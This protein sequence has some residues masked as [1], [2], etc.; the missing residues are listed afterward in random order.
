VDPA[1]R[2]VF[3]SAVCG[4]DPALREEVESLLA[5]AER[6]LNMLHQPVREAARSVAASEPLSHHRIGNFELIRL[7]GEGGMGEVYLAARA[8]DQFR[9]YVAIKLMRLGM[10]RAHDLLPRFLAERQILAN[11]D[12]P[13]IARLLDGGLTP[14]GWPYLVME[15]VDGIPIDEYCHCHRLPTVERLRLFRAVCSAV[16]HTHHNLVVHRDIKP[17]N[18]LI[19]TK[20]VPK[21]LDFGIAELVDATETDRDPTAPAVGMMTP[22][23]A[24]PEQILGKPV[25]TAA[26]VFALG[27]VLYELV[28]G[29]NP[30]RSKSASPLELRRDICERDPAPLSA[31]AQSN[32]DRAAPDARRCTPELDSILLKAMRKNPAERYQSAGQLSADIAAY[33]EG[34]PVSTYAG[35][36][37]YLANKF[38]RR[39]RAAVTLTVFAVV[40]LIAISI[41]MAALARRATVERLKAA[42][43]AQFLVDMFKAA[44]PEVARGEA[45]TARDLLDRGVKR[46]DTDLASVPA[47]Q[48][49]ML[50]S[51]AESYQGLGF[52]SKAEL[53]AERSYKM[54]SASRGPDDPDT[55]DTLFLLANL[56]RLQGDYARAEPLFREL[57]AIRR[58][59]AAADSLLYATSLNALGECL[60]LQSKDTEAEALLR[61]ALDIDRRNGPDVGTDGRN[62]LALLLQRKGDCQ[63]AVALLTE[64]VAIDA[65]TQGVNSPS[66]ASS[67]HNL[68]NALIDMGDLSGAEI[69]LHEAL[70]IRRKILLPSHPD[71]ASTLNTLGG[72]LLDKG[73]WGSAESYLRDALNI[74]AAGKDPNITAGWGRLLVAKGDRAAARFYFHQALE[75][76][77]RA[78]AFTSWQASQV[79]ID[80]GL[81]E[82]DDNNYEAAETQ[83]RQAM[84]MRRALGGERTPALASALVDVAE[85][86]L[87][88]DLPRNAEKL[89]RTALDIRSSKFPSTHA[90]V[91]GAKVRLG[92]ALVAEGEESEA[93]PLLREALASARSAPF[94]LLPWQ[95]AEAESALAASWIALG[96]IRDAAPLERSSQVGLATHPRPPLRRQAAVRLIPLNRA[97]HRTT[98]AAVSESRK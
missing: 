62:H 21:L 80:L 72:V 54:K 22:E 26:D 59:T 11:L 33:E 28:A 71:L 47:V 2:P 46:I 39:H 8:D 49:S 3:L 32:P 17:A 1:D 93:E 65:R 45:V 37:R 48:A 61:Q 77:R 68:G 42:R 90:G 73:D 13:N 60:Y 74:D 84:E 66:Y 35:N 79:F 5:A 82:F 34:R 30:F 7:I 36:W 19:N 14:E 76:L 16:E 52:Y 53:L 25:T 18:I 20:G 88:Q 24:S 55:A 50:H 86:Q 43:E 63:E 56:V 95:V 85:A 51:L 96:R 9:Q 81:V 89:L 15:L 67:L 97:A 64:A 6:T 75:R 87:F 38:V 40:G 70:A 31:T 44:T 92:E 78:N 83:A 4:G 23:Y 91:I 12:H 94:Q 27:V 29:R 41:S 69:K 57:V 98:R 10:E 58:K